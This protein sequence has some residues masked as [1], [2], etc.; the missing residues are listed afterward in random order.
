MIFILYSVFREIILN[1]KH[2][3]LFTPVSAI[4]AVAMFTF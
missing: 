3:L 4:P 2:G 1:V